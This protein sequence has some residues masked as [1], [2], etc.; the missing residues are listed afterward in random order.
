MIREL[1]LVFLEAPDVARQ[2]YLPLS[3][4]FS[5]T[6]EQAVM[7]FPE[8][9]I[10]KGFQCITMKR[11]IEFDAVNQ[12]I[13]EF[14]SG[15]T[16]ISLK[17][18]GRAEGEISYEDT[19]FRN[20]QV[21]LIEWT[22]GGSEFLTGVDLPVYIDSTPEDTLHRRVKRNR[23]ENAASELIKTVLDIEQKK[24]QEQAKNAK[25]VIGR[26]GGIY[27]Q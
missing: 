1:L 6:M 24:L 10:P 4:S 9:T 5:R 26:D 8:I 27:E 25:I 20:I 15:A 21:L 14:K 3:V 17:K 23:D 16:S 2:P 19:D 18:M 13:A 12:V 7:Y 11:E 22:H